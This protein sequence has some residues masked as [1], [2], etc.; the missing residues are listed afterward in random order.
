ME[1]ALSLDHVCLGIELRSS[2]WQQT[3]LPTEQLTG[4]ASL[5]F[6]HACGIHSLSIFLLLS[7]W[8]PSVATSCKGHRLRK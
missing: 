5:I 8:P 4:S 1:L 6:S 2:A 3:P 7:M